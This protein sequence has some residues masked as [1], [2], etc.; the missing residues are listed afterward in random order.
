[1]INTTTYNTKGVDRTTSALLKPITLWQSI[2]MTLAP[3]VLLYAFY[4]YMMPGLMKSFG[5]PFLVVYLIAWGGGE[6][7]I[8]LASL[9]VYKLEGNPP[10]WKAFA[11]RYRL[12]KMDR[13]DLIW[14]AGLFIVSTFTYFG[15][16][17]TA[18]WLAS[19]P[20][21][22]PPDFFPAELSPSGINIQVPGEF[23]GFPL[24]G[25]WWVLLVYFFGWLFNIFGE[26]F[27]FRGYMLP[28]QELAYKQYAW[29]VHGILF[30]CFHI[31]WKWNLIALLPGSL[32]MAYAV[33][34]RRNTW[35]SI[36]WHG[37]MNFIP[38]IWIVNGIL[39]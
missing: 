3:T 4:Y 24:K 5:Y 28:R 17:F 7:L 22:A 36:L 2:L 23:M 26:E 16:T 25:M 15:L 34:R 9:V 29:I 38:M 8:F 11:S 39:G 30:T 35:I 37:T 6:L 27:W 10:T 33:Q 19:M 14:L 21:F 31:F 18:E 12:H 32:F 20:A 1:M 13:M